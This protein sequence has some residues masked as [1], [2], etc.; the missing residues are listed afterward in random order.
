MFLT[1]AIFYRRG[2]GQITGSGDSAN[3]GMKKEAGGNDFFEKKRLSTT[4][5]HT[6]PPNQGQNRLST[7]DNQVSEVMTG[8]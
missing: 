7:N 1:A 2:K 4:N 8:R 5:A 6:Y 3:T